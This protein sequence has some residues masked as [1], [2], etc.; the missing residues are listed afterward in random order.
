MANN[1]TSQQWQTAARNLIQERAELDA[2]FDE[3]DKLNF[4]LSLEITRIS[5]ELRLRDASGQLVVPLGSE[6][7]S[8]LDQE[9]ARAVD[10]QRI[11]QVK[12]D[13][14]DG[15][16]EAVDEQIS[17]A[18]GL[19][20]Q[21]LRGPPNTN[22][23]TPPA[24]VEPNTAPTNVPPIDPIPTPQISA[25]A[26]AAALPSTTLFDDFGTPR[27][28]ITPVPAP[29]T[30]VEPIPPQPVTITTAPPDDPQ[31]GEFEAGQFQIAQELRTAPEPI[32]VLDPETG[33]PVETLASVEARQ[34]FAA[35][36]TGISPYGEQDD[37]PEFPADVD[38]TVN[39]TQGYPTTFDE[40]GNE[41]PVLPDDNLAFTQGVDNTSGYGVSD[42]NLAF[43]SLPDDNLAFEQEAALAAAARERARVQ[44]ILANQQ[45]QADAGDWRLKL[46]LAPGARY[47]YRGEDG[48]GVQTGILAPL[49]VTDGVIFPYTPTINTNYAA[50]YSETDLPHSNYRGYFYNNSF[51]EG[52]NIEAVFTAQDTAEANYLLAVIHFFRSVTKMFYGQ[53]DTNRGAP[54]PMVFLQGF[55]AYQFSRH[56]C[57]V[58]NFRYTLP[59]NVD[60][61]R[62][63]V[64]PIA[65]LNIQQRRSPG[66]VPPQSL[67][68]NV[69]TGALARLSAAGVPKG[70][71]NRAPPAE[72]LGTNSPT[73]VPTK[74]DIAIDLLPMQSRQQVSQGFNMKD[75][76]SGALIKKGFW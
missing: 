16:I 50:R 49:A 7:R 43:D 76:A 19:A 60:Y 66:G 23:V 36:E 28:Q 41:I 21:S 51:V 14:I 75:F 57:V 15:K 34:Q 67:P 45:R 32:T 31:A 48:Q 73:Y 11:N 72:T 33:L 1:N 6:R 27:A 10:Q 52:I 5:D 2:Q 8:Q 53:D 68:T 20:Q 59:S 46:R 35:Q 9:I 54:P 38:T 18:E 25:V 44:A 4:G 22:A 55:G 40:F 26:P 39:D 37:A 71:V 13:L 42:D 69:F 17:A 58:S 47:L 70:A 56:P 65:G 61:I 62:A 29:Q 63:D 3:L 30:T 64:S 12:Q 74:I 24:T